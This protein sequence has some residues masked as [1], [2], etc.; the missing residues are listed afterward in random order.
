MNKGFTL[1]ELTI[2]VTIFVGMTVLLI[3]K[4]GSFNQSTLLTD[5]SYDIALVMRQA[6]TYG[7]SVVNASQGSASFQYSYGISFSTY[8][9]Q[10]SDDQSKAG[11][12]RAIL[13][14]DSYPLNGNNSVGNGAYDLTSRVPASS[15]LAQSVYNLTRGAKIS[16]LCVGTGNVTGSIPECSTLVG[17]LDITFKRPDPTAIIRSVANGTINSPSPYAEVTIAGTG[18]STRTLAVSSNG[19]ISILQ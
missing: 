18:G 4:Y 6:Q 16:K 17:E 5:L 8:T 3:V 14:A 1:I 2:C 19:Q 13:F 12:T 7:L 11:S 9:L 10:A 15:D